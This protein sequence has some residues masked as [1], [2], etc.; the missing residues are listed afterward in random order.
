MDTQGGILLTHVVLAAVG[1]GGE[2]RSAVQDTG[3][4]ASGENPPEK[5]GRLHSVRRLGAWGPFAWRVAPKITFGVGPASQ[6]IQSL[7][8]HIYVLIY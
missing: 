2:F 6:N 5:E 7:E 4:K 3:S 8:I 1:Y